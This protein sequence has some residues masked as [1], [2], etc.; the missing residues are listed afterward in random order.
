M[1]NG[2]ERFAAYGDQ[3]STG[4]SKWY[5]MTEDTSKGCYTFTMDTSGNY[6][7]V[8]FLR[9]DGSKPENDFANEW[10]RTPGVP[11]GSAD[12]LAIP[13]DGTN[14]FVQG[15]ENGGWNNCGGSWT[16]K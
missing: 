7:R 15:T 3:K 2:N 9:M 8:I 5:S 14:C 11:K 10:N 1:K 13:T 12:G 6:D 16:T 4:Y